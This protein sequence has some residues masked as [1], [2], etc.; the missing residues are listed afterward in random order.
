MVVG[1]VVNDR[2]L[3]PK[4]RRPPQ[5]NSRDP[6]AKANRKTDR[7]THG[8]AHVPDPSYFYGKQNLTMLLSAT[9]HVLYRAA[10]NCQHSQQLS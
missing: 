9:D 6:K 8:V 3:K 4:V 1:V 10:D 2:S 7:R 5:L